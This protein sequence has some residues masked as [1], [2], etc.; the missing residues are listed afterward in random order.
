MKYFQHGERII[1]S[2]RNAKRY[3]R[4][5]P[6]VTGL[7]RYWWSGSDLIEVEDYTRE[8]ILNKASQDLN[9]GMTA[10]WAV[11]HHAI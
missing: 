7:E 3:L 2:V 1:G 10:Q 9:K 4:D 11:D 8:E 5:N 6:D